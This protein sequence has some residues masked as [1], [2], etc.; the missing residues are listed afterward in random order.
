MYLTFTNKNIEIYFSE[1]RNYN[2]LTREEEVILFARINRGDQAAKD[3][4]FH[5]M[6][7]MAVMVAK[8]YTGNPDLLQDLIQEANMGILT[9]IT[10]YDPTRDIRFSSYARWWMKANITAFLNSM[11]VVHPSGNKWIDLAKKIREE[12]FKTH[13]RDITEFELLDKIEEATGE[14]IKDLSAVSKILLS[15]IDLPVDED[16]NTGAE[17]GEFADRTAD[18][19]DYEDT[20]EN[21]ELSYDISRRMA[22]LDTREQTLVRMKFGIGYPYEM[23]YPNIAESWNRDHEKKLTAERVRQIITNALVKMR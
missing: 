1:I 12:F 7:K 15:R 3:E 4:V 8:T 16:E 13:H 9:A 21:E 19:N 22:R 20:I 10:K 11:E 14:I 2:D 6:S 23:E 18:K 17:F 5:R